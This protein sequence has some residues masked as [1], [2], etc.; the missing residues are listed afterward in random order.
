MEAGALNTT[1][2]SCALCS[3]RP[4]SGAGYF[5]GGSLAG[6]LGL[7]LAV[8]AFRLRGADAV[9]GI[10]CAA[11]TVLGGALLLTG[12]VRGM[13]SATPPYATG[14]LRLKATTVV[15][16]QT[17]T[18][19]VRVTPDHTL[20][21]RA[22]TVE[23]QAYELVAGEEKVI[24]TV[25]VPLPL[26]ATLREVV[27]REVRLPV[28]RDWPPSMVSPSGISPHRE[29]RSRVRVNLDADAHPLLVMDAP[30]TVGARG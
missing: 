19:R 7:G 17:V 5:V 9:S 3:R 15:P 25:E 8:I 2:G 26:P 27:R 12:L 6:A 14:A 11:G 24:K 22:A 13:R 18:G 1:L 4:P 21:L 30:L 20:H 10:A 23:L 28:P 16:G 29:I